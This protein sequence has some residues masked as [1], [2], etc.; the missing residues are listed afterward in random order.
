MTTNNDFLKKY[1]YFKQQLENAKIGTY[2]PGQI[3]FFTGLDKKFCEMVIQHSIVVDGSNA[4]II[5]NNDVDL[6]CGEISNDQ[7]EQYYYLN[8]IED[9]CEENYLYTLNKA[10][11]LNIIDDD[12]YNFKLSI[13]KIYMEDYLDYMFGFIDEN[14]TIEYVKD[15]DPIKEILIKKIN[16]EID[17]NVK[18][19]ILESFKKE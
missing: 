11:E 3:K 5:K 17:N 12:C 13:G 4:D 1:F 15:N 16:E 6:L 8:T 14:C 19:K 7:T 9:T 10:P 18:E 2:N